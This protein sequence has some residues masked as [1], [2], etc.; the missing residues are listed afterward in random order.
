[1]RNLKKV[2]V[3]NRGEIALRVIRGAKDAG[4]S[5]VAVFADSDCDAPFVRAADE[6]VALGGERASETYLDGDKIIAAAKGTRADA[7]HPG[8]GFLAENADFAQDVIEAGITWV[9]P[10]PASIRALG[11]K[12]SARDIARRAGAPLAPG[13]PGPVASV[14]EVLA[15]AD[16]HGLP[17]AI[18]AVFGGGGRGL[19][20]ARE[21]ANIPALFDAAVREATAA[22]GRGECYVERYLDRPRHVETQVIADTHGNVI[23]LGTRDCSLQR[24]SQKVVEEAPAP[25]LTEAQRSQLYESSKAIFREAEYQGAGTVEFLI[26]SDGL[27]S[28]L[29]VNT[30]LQVEH[31]ITEETTGLDLVREQIRIAEGHPLSLSEDPE[32]RGHSIEFRVN[33]EDPGRGFF[34]TTGRVV[35]EVR[36]TGPGVRL[37]TGIESG[38][39]VSEHFDSLL[40]KL[41]V[42]GPDRE[43]A[44]RRARRVLQEYRI[45]GVPTLLPFHRIIVNDPDFIAADGKFG[46]HTQWLEN[47][48][49]NTLEPY[50]PEV[51]DSDGDG[52]V[53]EATVVLG[54]VQFHI[55]QVGSSAG[56]ARSAPLGRSARPNSSP[57]RQPAPSRRAP[58]RRPSRTSPDAAV[59]VPMQGT[60]IAMLIGEGDFV[61]AGDVLLVLEAMKMENPVVAHRSG[62]ITGLM[63]SVGK[64]L[65]SGDLVCEIRDSGVG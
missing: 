34:P 24:R 49:L 2:L 19:R 56:S 37:D 7:I 8:Y 3:A 41:I 35:E 44:L 53:E 54:G 11:D 5:S 48:W 58:P 28:F 31:P 38:S 20:V 33:A 23:V 16:T 59:A 22:F 51:E 36:P 12:V 55:R 21:R 9:G 47:D 42:T 32:P 29:E 40:A 50:V 65:S 25:F 45:V 30:R 63:V 17:I 18:K 62:V 6:S 1:M 52:T 61:Q 10:S 57:V 39:L 46:V 13:T 27:V 4:L 26:A 14:E 60:V 64:T 43:S 15:F